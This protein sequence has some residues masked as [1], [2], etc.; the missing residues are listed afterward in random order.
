MMTLGDCAVKDTRS[1]RLRT[2]GTLADVLE[3]SPAPVTWDTKQAAI[4][5]QHATVQTQNGTDP[6]SN[7]QLRS[8]F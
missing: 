4:G 6:V 7:V 1:R 2:G 8:V 5:D 3:S